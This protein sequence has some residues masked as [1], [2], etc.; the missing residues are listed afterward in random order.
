M[1][2]VQRELLRRGHQSGWLKQDYTLLLEKQQRG[3]RVTEK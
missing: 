3:Y 1:P 2:S